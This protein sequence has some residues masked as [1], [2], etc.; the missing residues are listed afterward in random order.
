VFIILVASLKKNGMSILTV[1]NI[2][3]PY[4]LTNSLLIYTFM[5]HS[6]DVIQEAMKVLPHCELIQESSFDMLIT[7]L[8]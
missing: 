5:D 1:F 7:D 6:D 4:I 8:K 2:K 3:D